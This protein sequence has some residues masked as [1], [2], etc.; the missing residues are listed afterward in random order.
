MKYKNFIWQTTQKEDRIIFSNAH[1]L[2]CSHLMGVPCCPCIECSHVLT[3]WPINFL[4]PWRM[5]HMVGS[6]LLDVGH[7]PSCAQLCIVKNVTMHLR[8]V[9]GG[10]SYV[11]HMYSWVVYMNANYIECSHVLRLVSWFR[12]YFCLF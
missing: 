11:Y 2:G 12:T 4:Y 5:R 10:P 8:N 9:K 6:F 7:A 1:R 3:T